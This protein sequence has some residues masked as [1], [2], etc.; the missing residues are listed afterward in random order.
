MKG[1]ARVRNMC[2]TA[3]MAAL[4]CAVAPMS[5]PAGAIPFTLATFGVCLCGALLGSRRG[6]AA[7]GVYLLIGAAGLPV[8]SGY[9][10]GLQKL[11]GATGGYLIGY[12]P[13]AWIIGLAADRYSGKRWMLSA[14]MIAGTAVCYAVGT[15]WFMRLTGAS[16]K[17]SLAGCVVPFLPGD[18]VKIAAAS[19]LSSA[20]RSRVG[21][22][23]MRK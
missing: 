20:L 18:A 19:A 4:L 12:L 14:A 3:M 6:T 22:Q 15:A 16:L 5:V 7:V 9:A 8:F 2:E 11:A 13:C 17:A 23:R 1:T 21:I 10:G